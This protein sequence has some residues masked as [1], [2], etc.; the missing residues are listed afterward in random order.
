VERF[1]VGI[2]DLLGNS[3][4]VGVL[5]YGN[6]NPPILRYYRLKNSRG[7]FPAHRGPN[8]DHMWAPT[9]YSPENRARV[10]TEVR[11]QFRNAALV[12]VPEYLDDYA[13]HGSHAFMHFRS[14]WAAWLNSADAPK[15][16][17][18]MLVEDTSRLRLLVLQREEHA[19]GQGDPWRLPYGNRDAKPHADYSPAVIRFR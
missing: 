8:W 11:E 3:G 13:G 16:R 6:Y 12:V 4:G 5:W 19:R 2:D 18:R 9:D 1:A 14:D 15:M 7:D 17:V 10:M